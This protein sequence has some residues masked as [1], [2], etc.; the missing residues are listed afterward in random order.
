MFNHSLCL[1]HSEDR[2][3]ANAVLQAIHQRFLGGN[4]T[5]FVLL[6]I[7]SLENIGGKGKSGELTIS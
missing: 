5:A 3:L 6:I 1:K 7:I 2:E 4:S